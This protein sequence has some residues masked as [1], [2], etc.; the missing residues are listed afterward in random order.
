M[1]TSTKSRTNYRKTNHKLIKRKKTQ[2]RGMKGGRLFGTGYGANCNDTNYSI[3]NTNML[4]L[5]P[6]KA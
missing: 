2:K 5:F 3:F 1:K 4:K 6:Y